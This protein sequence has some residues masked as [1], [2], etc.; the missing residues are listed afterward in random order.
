MEPETSKTVRG[1]QNQRVTRIQNPTSCRCF[2]KASLFPDHV[3]R[4]TAAQ[5]VCGAEACFI[6]LKFLERFCLYVITWFHLNLMYMDFYVFGFPSCL[7]MRH[8][9]GNLIAECSRTGDIVMTLMF[10][11]IKADVSRGCLIQIK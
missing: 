4:P 3:K 10:D 8:I 11:K 7:V 2:L 5:Q 6:S 9:L 1:L